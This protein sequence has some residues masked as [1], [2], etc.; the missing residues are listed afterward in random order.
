MQ[1]AQIQKRDG[2]VFITLYR[3]EICRVIGP[4]TRKIKDI[5]N[6]VKFVSP[7]FVI[8]R[9]FEKLLTLLTDNYLPPLQ[10]RTAS[11]ELLPVA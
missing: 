9:S 5:K 8:Y 6:E 11:D 2:E 4:N 10:K 3:R 1:L 7:H